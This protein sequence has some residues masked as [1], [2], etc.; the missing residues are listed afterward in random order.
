MMKRDAF[1]VVGIILLIWSLVDIV[2]TIVNKSWYQLAW[3]SNNIV[4]ILSLAFIFRNKILMSAVAVSSL[5]VELPWFID[6]F[7]RL[8]FNFVP[9]GGLSDYMFYEITVKNW[10]FY[11][12]LNHLVLIP[13]SMYGMYKLGVHKKAYLICWIFI[14]YLNSLAYFLTPIE[15]NINCVNRLCFLRENFIK[16]NSFSYYVLW[17]VSLAVVVYLLNKLIYYLSRKYLSK[18]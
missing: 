5:I 14:L 18:V 6:F 17:M 10:L 12:E 8:L 13:L 3:F 16:V 11:L 1:L 15:L 2:N 4:L 7:G 9:F